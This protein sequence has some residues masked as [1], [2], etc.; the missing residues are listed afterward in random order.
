MKFKL[1]IFTVVIAFFQVNAQNNKYLNTESYLFKTADSSSKKLGYFK[2]NASVVLIE[3][4]GN[5]WS[6]IKT[7]NLDT[8]YILT[9]NLSDKYTSS[10]RSN[11]LKDNPIS[12]ANSNFGNYHSYITVAS[13]RIRNKPSLDSEIVGKLSCGQAVPVKYLP[14]DPKSWVN[15]TNSRF[16]QR[17]FLGEKPTHNNLVEKYNNIQEQDFKNRLKIAERIVELS[18]NSNQTHLKE[19]YQILNNLA[20][21]I[22][23]EKLIKNSQFFIEYALGQLNKKNESEIEDFIKNADF[24]IKGISVKN[25]FV[26]LSEAIKT[27]GEPKDV[28]NMQD[29]CGI[30]YSNLFYFYDNINLSV[31]KEENLAN[32]DYIQLSKNFKFK[33]N[34]N[35]IIDHTI[36]ELNFI[37]KYAS[38]IRTNIN[39]PNRYF[40]QNDD[41]GYYI[42]FKNGYAYSITVFSIC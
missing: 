24:I 39:Y 3:S 12:N 38:Y 26:K 34:Q 1:I 16:V 23:D 41:G 40:W 7:D 32:I 2:P 10:K 13:L 18:W 6:N 31:N 27:F 35:N 4:L 11:I 33:I 42:E 36:S 30:Y 20:V 22:K 8:G 25:Q 5:G 15:I 9:K 14:V 17:Q 37:K 29:E 21:E 19:A 28:K